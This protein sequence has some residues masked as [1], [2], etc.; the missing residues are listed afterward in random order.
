MAFGAWVAA[1]VAVGWTAGLMLVQMAS[2]P[3][4]S[5]LLVLAASLFLGGL[6][7]LLRRPLT[8]ALVLG[9]VGLGLLRASFTTPAPALSIPP[10]GQGVGLVVTAGP[11]EQIGGLW[12]FIGKAEVASGPLQ[13]GHKV[14]VYLEAPPKGEGE[15][16]PPVQRGDRLYL[17]GR[18]HPLPEGRVGHALS[19]QGVVGVLRFPEA[20]LLQGGGGFLAAVDRLRWRLALALRRAIHQP[21]AGFGQALLLGIRG[22]MLPEEWDAFRQAG[23]A[24]LLAVSGMH[25]ALV[26]GIL[27]AF[28]FAFVGRRAWGLGVPLVGLW[29][30][31]ILTGLG[32]PVVRAAVMGSMALGARAVGR[33]Y[34]PMASLAVT[35]GVMAGLSPSILGQVSFQLSVAGMAGL[36]VLGMPLQALLHRL[37]GRWEKGRPWLSALVGNGALSLGASLGA[38]PLAALTFE[39]LPVLG[40]VSTF[41]SL[42]LLLP[43]LVLSGVTALLGL[44][45]EQLGSLIAWPTWV[46]L[47]GLRLPSVWLAQVPWA[48]ISVQSIAPWVWGFYAVLALLRGWPFLLEAIPQWVGGRPLVFR[49]AFPLLGVA[50]VLVWSAA[51]QVPSHRLVLEAFPDGSWVLYGPRGQVVVATAG[52]DPRPV[53]R[54]LGARLPFWE[55]RVSLLVVSAPRGVPAALEVL[56]RYTTDRVVAVPSGE[57][58][59]GVLPL[60]KGVS[61]DLRGGLWV[62]VEEV[63]PTPV[64][65]ILWGRVVW[66]LKGSPWAGGGEGASM[67]IY[68]ERGPSGAYLVAMAGGERWEVPLGGWLK[69]TA[70]QGRVWVQVKPGVP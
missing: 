8:P 25:V 59:S 30:Y 17:S 55:R 46:V 68:R 18:V 61:A 20:S 70:E 36:V 60:Q 15:R 43:A 64:F 34:A 39:R 11:P 41:L 58:L 52:P 33:P 13:V 32:P 2:V 63:M 23:T 62:E 19:H 44:A 53:L 45:W 3:W 66:L 9:A 5:S 42:P 10:A 7:A 37:T 12:R 22:D 26:L 6:L 47:A 4:T 24:H 57:G 51:L 21:E 67:L 38:V 1:W 50:A 16:W 48:S 14:L 35:V 65:R 31:A 69:V 54:T 27:E 49:G 56:R 28:T 29:G 40:V